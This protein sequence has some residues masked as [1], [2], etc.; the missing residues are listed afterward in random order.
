MKNILSTIITAFIALAIIV[1]SIVMFIIKDV[2]F[3]SLQK[4]T[5]LVLGI[6]LLV[7]ISYCFIVGEITRNNSQMDK[8]WSILPAIYTWII[9]GMG[10][11]NIRLVIMAIVATIW[12]ARLTYNFA[13]KGAYSI[14]FWSGE[15]DYRWVILRNSKYFKSKIVWA[16]FD[17]IFISIYQNVLVFLTIVPSLAVMESAK[18]FNWIDI[19][20]VVCCGLAIL[21]EFIADRQQ[22]NFQSKKWAM[23]KSGKKLEELEEPYNL[24]FNTTGIW[25]Y[26]RHPNYFGE[27]ATWVSLYIFSIAGG[28]SI[29]NYSFFGA[30]ML[31]LLFMGS[32]MM[33]EIISSSKYPMY[34]DYQKKVCKYLPIFKY[35]K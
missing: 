25:K 30:G 1:S 32:S 9:A 24:G 14:R 16:L 8:L 33:A 5:L 12:G 2:R 10:H 6:V 4:D 28:L 35:K 15:E 3:S 23:I 11:W 21:L 17:L 19:V 34:K 13:K 20:A 18:A 29:I 7:S 26:S 22:W 27:Q 31:I